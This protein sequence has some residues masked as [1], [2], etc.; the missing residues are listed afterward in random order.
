MSFFHAAKQEE[1]LGVTHS[2]SSSPT[3]TAISSRVT[4]KSDPSVSESHL[5]QPPGPSISVSCSDSNSSITLS[6]AHSVPHSVT[7]CSSLPCPPIPEHSAVQSFQSSADTSTGLVDSSRIIC[8]SQTLPLV[9]EKPI[10]KGILPFVSLSVSIHSSLV[11]SSSALTI[12]PLS[13]TPTYSTPSSSLFVSASSHVTESSESKIPVLGSSPSKDSNL[14]RISS[15]VSH[16][17]ELSKSVS[18]SYF[19]G[20]RSTSSDGGCGTSVS[21]SAV[22]Q[23]SIDSASV[24]ATHIT[25][26]ISPSYSK[27]LTA[28]SLLSLHSDVGSSLQ[29]TPSPIMSHSY[30]TPAVTSRP[31]VGHSPTLS[32]KFAASSDIA[33]HSHTLSS[34]SSSSLQPSDNIL[35]EPSILTR[36]M[37]EPASISLLSFSDTSMPSTVLLSDTLAANAASCLPDVPPVEDTSL[38]HLI[39]SQS[40]ESHMTTSEFTSDDSVL[41]GSSTASHSQSS[42]L[43]T[44]VCSL[45]AAQDST[46]LGPSHI[47]PSQLTPSPPTPT[48]PQSSDHLPQPPPPEPPSISPPTTPRKGPLK[49]ISSMVDLSGYN[50]RIVSFLARNFYNLKY[51]ALVM[52]FCINFILLF[53][54]ATVVES[55]E[56]EEEEGGTNPFDFGSGDLLG[57]GD[58][59]V[60]GDDG[61]ADE[62]GSGNFT[63]E[64]DGEEEEE[65]EENKE[66]EGGS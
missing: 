23:S 30:S 61:G 59:A 22:S 29:Q 21:S 52:A 49:K 34:L 33:P 17:P 46:L 56:E 47:D 9:P 3:S 20:M 27:P 45:P 8:R 6:Q 32:S 11:Q 26:F 36:S 25:S 41:L 15:S 60:L 39:T 31:T 53:F 55:D 64:D 35:T 48:H 62:G 40:M 38:Q 1:P 43:E 54:K 10:S 16:K 13:H 42:L 4:L 66:Q 24:P 28:S 19:H 37:T 2:I 14:S 12:Q 65:E 18:S 50:K 58:D 7:S 51:A 57:S 63:L 5:S 44:Q